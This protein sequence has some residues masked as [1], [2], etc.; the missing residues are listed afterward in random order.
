[1]PESFRDLLLRYRARTGLTQRDL[2]ARL[3]IGRRTLQDWET[4]I[5]HPSAERLQALIEGLKKKDVDVH[6][7]YSNSLRDFANSRIRVSVCCSNARF[8][9]RRRRAISCSIENR[10]IGKSRN[11]EIAKWLGGKIGAPK[12]IRTSDLQLRRLSLYPA[13]LWA[14]VA[15]RF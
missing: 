5:S 1:M 10:E 9:I 4:G 11:R 14:R 6:G 7:G 3:G 15:S 8:R 12:R 2:A 13:E